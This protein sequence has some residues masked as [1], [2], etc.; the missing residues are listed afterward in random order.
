[1]ALAQ[2]AGA[3]R[4]PRMAY[5][6]SWSRPSTKGMREIGMMAGRTER[7]NGWRLGGQSE[8]HARPIRRRE[9]RLATTFP[10]DADVF[11]G[12]AARCRHEGARRRTGA[13]GRRGRRER[14]EQEKRRRAEKTD[15]CAASREP[16]VLHQR[17]LRSPRFLCASVVRPFPPSTPC[18]CPPSPQS[19]PSLNSRACADRRHRARRTTPYRACG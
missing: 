8:N 15:P 10:R 17:L 18:A 2:K 11:G 6:R 13:T 3:R 19:P 16:S 4:S 12:C 1:M 14:N 7:G 5:L 9:G